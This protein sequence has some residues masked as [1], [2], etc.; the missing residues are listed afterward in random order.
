MSTNEEK[1]KMLMDAE[2]NFR[3]VYNTYSYLAIEIESTMIQQCTT[4][5]LQEM[6]EKLTS[7]YPDVEKAYQDVVKQAESPNLVLR[8]DMDR[9]NA[10]KDLVLGALEVRLM[11]VR[12]DDV[13]SSRSARHSSKSSRLSSR[14]GRS[15]ISAKIAEAAAQIAAHKD[16]LEASK[17]EAQI[18][19]ISEEISELRHQEALRQAI[20]EA[21]LEKK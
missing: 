11:P 9:L 16:E 17:K 14:S 19:E 21:S 2:E 10:D 15:S 6:K 3:K 20:A 5:Q 4:T 8:R 1:N 12:D 7:T 18:E 13:K